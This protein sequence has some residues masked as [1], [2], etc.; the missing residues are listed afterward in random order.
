M[1]DPQLSYEELYAD[2]EQ[3]IARLESGELPLDEALRH[4]ERGMVI[5]AHCQSLLDQAELRLQRLSQG[6]IEDLTLE[7]EE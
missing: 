2:L 5:A 7:G 1:A 3:T 6:L 4:Y